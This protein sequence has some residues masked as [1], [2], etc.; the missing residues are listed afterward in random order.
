[1]G[2]GRPAYL[3]LL[4]CFHKSLSGNSVPSLNLR[5]RLGQLLPN[6]SSTKYFLSE[7]HRYAAQKDFCSKDHLG[8]HQ[9]N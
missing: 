2:D 4:V 1:M 8:K 5:D 3:G 7:I 6:R 9:A